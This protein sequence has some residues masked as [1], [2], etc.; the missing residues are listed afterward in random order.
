MKYVLGTV[1]NCNI[2]I[3]FDILAFFS[4]TIHTYVSLQPI[5]SVIIGV[6]SVLTQAIDYLN[7]KY[8][9]RLVLSWVAHLWLN[10][11]TMPLN[12]FAMKMISGRQRLGVFTYNSLALVAKSR[13]N[14]KVVC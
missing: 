8:N 12:R 10:I 9:I 2:S 11:P 7:D 6:L 13:K 4:L 3:E 5:F 1:K 14:Y